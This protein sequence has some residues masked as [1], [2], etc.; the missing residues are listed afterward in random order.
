MRFHCSLASLLGLLPITAWSGPIGAIIV[1]LIA[2]T[3]TLIAGQIAFMIL[4]SPSIRAGIA[5]LL[6]VPAAIAGYYA[7]LG[8]VHIGIPTEGWRRA[9]ALIGAIVVAATA[10]MR[11]M[12]SA[13]RPTPDNS[14]PLP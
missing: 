14:L 6:A 9:M 8:L 4:R 3:I 11:M 5:L 1:G 13:P 2:S 7:A 10:W 12:L